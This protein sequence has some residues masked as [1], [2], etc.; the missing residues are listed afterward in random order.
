ME[1]YQGL[2]EFNSV[3][4]DDTVKRIHPVSHYKEIL[5]GKNQEV[6]G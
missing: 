5:L 1:M 6:H 3:F 2:I 4:T